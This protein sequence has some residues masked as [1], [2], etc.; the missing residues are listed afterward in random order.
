MLNGFIERCNKTLRTEILDMDF[1]RS[2]S[3]V[4]TLIEDW[5]TEYNEERPHSSLGYFPEIIYAR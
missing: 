3:E 5:H 2:P 4:R 1:F